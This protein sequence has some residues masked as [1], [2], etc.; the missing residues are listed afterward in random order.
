VGASSCTGT[1]VCLS[2]PS[3]SCGDY[4]C[5]AGGIC[6]SSCTIDTDCLTGLSCSAGVC[7]PTP[8]QPTGCGC[9]GASG[10][11]VLAVLGALGLLRRRRR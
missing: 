8:P 4:V 9:S 1:G 5:K 6:P 7:A 11:E 3:V 2:P 10:A